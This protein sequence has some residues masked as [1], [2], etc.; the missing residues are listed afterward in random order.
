[1]K[2]VTFRSTSTVL[3]TSIIV[4][5]IM[6]L[7]LLVVGTSGAT[8]TRTRI[9]RA[10]TTLKTNHENRLDTTRASGTREAGPDSSTMYGTTGTG[11]TAGA[12]RNL[13]DMIRAEID[14]LLLD[15][16]RLFESF[17]DRQEDDSGDIH[18]MNE[19]LHRLQDS[20][21]DHL[22]NTT[23]T[24]MHLSTL[25]LQHQ[26]L[27]D[28]PPSTGIIGTMNNPVMSFND[29]NN[30]GLGHDD[31]LWQGHGPYYSSNTSELSLAASI[32][33]EAVDKVVRGGP[34]ELVKSLAHDA[35]ASLDQ[36][37][38][39]DDEMMIIRMKQKMAMDVV[40]AIYEQEGRMLNH[41]E[42]RFKTDIL[43][44]RYEYQQWGEERHHRGEMDDESSSSARSDVI[45]ERLLGDEIWIKAGYMDV[46]SIITND[47]RNDHVDGDDE[48]KSQSINIIEG[49]S[50]ERYKLRN[51]AKK[52]LLV[53]S[54]SK[55]GDEA[56]TRTHIGVREF[57]WGDLLLQQQQKQQQ[58]RGED[59]MNT[60]GKTMSQDDND[61]TAMMVDSKMILYYNLRAISDIAHETDRIRGKIKALGTLIEEDDSNIVST[62][63]MIQDKVEYND[64]FE[65]ITELA[66]KVA[67]L[68]TNVTVNKII[69]HSM[70][71][72]RMLKEDVLNT[73]YQYEIDVLD[74][75]TMSQLHMA[76]IREQM[77]THRTKHEIEKDSSLSLVLE[78]LNSVDSYLINA[79]STSR[80][81]H[82]WM[83][84]FNKK[85]H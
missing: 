78:I 39:H 8:S 72:K 2:L 58:Q 17:V 20:I 83:N 34:H 16:N 71:M 64:D 80:F 11:S 35:I 84:Y 32:M 66:E 67:A 68:E 41:N 30:T 51:D 24:T 29:T 60:S 37:D 38:N 63:R 56:R 15:S 1:M 23:T 85:C 55:S 49:L 52:D 25:S 13:V 50:L 82:I 26:T 6:M 44:Q 77:V 47:E 5:M 57:D 74:G 21:N 46:E 76:N 48:K 73:K 18:A 36:L 40:Y 4:A 62:I 3:V 75:M 43:Q 69:L 61:P 53:S 54:G 59:K 81:V 28:V 12:G 9:P 42:S 10:G 27:L 33:N 31:F 22:M 14:S 19:Y 45:D 79:N 70:D 65:S 7:L